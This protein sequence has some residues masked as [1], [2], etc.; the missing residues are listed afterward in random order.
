M[1]HMTLLRVVSFA[2]ALAIPVRGLAAT[3]LDDHEYDPDNGAEIMELCA[4]CHG[5]FGQGGG[6]GEYPRLAGLPAKYLAAQ[7]R[8][9]KERK[10]ENMAMAPYANER[11]MPEDDLLDISIYFS[12]LELPA[13]MP[14][15]DPDLD[16][17]QKLLI[18]RRVF[19]VPRLEGDIERGSDVYA[20]QCL[21]CHGEAGRG[22]GNVPRLAGQYSEYLRLQLA[23]YKS[24]ER[25]SRR[26]QKYARELTGEDLAALLSYLSVADD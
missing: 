20:S 19:N 18:A 23:A 14:V 24:G 8:E 22:R 7:M 17:L 25:P 21:R 9:F 11:E 5:E 3:G 13:Q 6:G 15:V 26:M 12:R 1:T 4:G 10:R 2:L 16:S